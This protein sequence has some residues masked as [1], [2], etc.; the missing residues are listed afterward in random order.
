MGIVLIHLDK[1]DF[2]HDIGSG[3]NRHPSGN[4]NPTLY[5]RDYRS[6]WEKF[7]ILEV[8]YGLGIELTLPLKI[9]KQLQKKTDLI[10]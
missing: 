6:K 4:K 5:Y 1:D 9:Q 3:M 8:S 2:N 7:L 10:I